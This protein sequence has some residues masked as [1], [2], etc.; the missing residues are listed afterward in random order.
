MLCQAKNEESGF[1]P[2]FQIVKEYLIRSHQLYK[3]LM[4]MLMTEITKKKDKKENELTLGSFL[5][6]D[7]QKEKFL[8]WYWESPPN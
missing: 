1:L 8:T 2:A 4:M 7:E 3:R 6:E 5:D